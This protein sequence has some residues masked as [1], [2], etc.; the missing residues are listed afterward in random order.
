MNTVALS[1]IENRIR[2]F[3]IAEQLWLV[4]R[5]AQNIREQLAVKPSL[6][7]QLAMMAADPNTQRELRAIEEEFEVAMSDGLESE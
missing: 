7:E 3:S 6:E 4:E 2:Q 5:V 1:E